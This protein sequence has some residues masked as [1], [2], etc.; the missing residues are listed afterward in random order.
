MSFIFPDDPAPNGY[1]SNPYEKEQAAA[2]D[3]MKRE[4]DSTDGWSS[5][6][7]HCVILTA[8]RISRS[9]HPVGIKNGVV[10]EKKTIAGDPSTI[11]LVRGKGLIKNFFP[12]KFY[13][14]ATLPG[15]RIHWD[16]RYLEGQ[17]LE[18]Y[19]RRSYKFYG[20]QKYELPS[21][22]LTMTHYVV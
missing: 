22:S 13:P 9:N 16:A 12:T 4:C 8:H 5:I 20:V 1:V 7:R 21:L 17:A 6:G 2:Y 3:Y 19:S 18:R 15:A 10:M 11:P 14:L